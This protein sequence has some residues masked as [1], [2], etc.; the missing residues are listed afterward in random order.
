MDRDSRF[1]TAL[2]RVTLRTDIQKTARL[3][4]NCVG[5]YSKS[6]VSDSFVWIAILSPRGAVS[7]KKQGASMQR[8]RNRGVWAAACVIFL[9][10]CASVVQAQVNTAT[11]SG[12]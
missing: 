12:T 8:M 4:L 1:A 10:L 3:E 5:D 7:P 11:L 6:Q 9:F 2:L